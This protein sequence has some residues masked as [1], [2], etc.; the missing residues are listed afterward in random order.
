MGIAGPTE[1][2]GDASAAVAVDASGDPAVAAPGGSAR[3]TIATD[4]VGQPAP[5]SRIADR[6]T[7]TGFGP[8]DAAAAGRA[9]ETSA[10]APKPGNAA[11]SDPRARA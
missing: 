8:V 10:A 1:A 6:A 5:D 3:E 2:A 11:I 7:S 9:E 4:P